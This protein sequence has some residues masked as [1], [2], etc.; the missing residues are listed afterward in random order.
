MGEERKV[1]NDLVGKPEGKSP[2]GRPR[3][4]WEDGIRMDLEEIGWRRV[5]C[6]NWLSTGT[7]GGLL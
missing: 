1:Y 2:L 3:H 6:I 7:G 4:T 5:E